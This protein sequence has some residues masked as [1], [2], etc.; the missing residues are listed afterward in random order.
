M[1]AEP[2][3]RDVSLPVS[4]ALW[5][6]R[7][8][9]GRAADRA[10]PATAPLDVVAALNE[11]ANE[12]APAEGGIAEAM[13]TWLTPRLRNADTLSQARIVP[14]LGMAAEMIAHSAEISP[15]IARLGALALEQ[16]L[17][18]Q[19]ALAERRAGLTL[20]AGQNG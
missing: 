3:D 16:E 10:A 6:A 20:A 14:L 5:G 9:E 1:A 15:D 12:A 13:M 2:L 8:I 11:L 17:R 7:R 4:D 18:S 19:R